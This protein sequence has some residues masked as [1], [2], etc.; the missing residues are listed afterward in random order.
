MCIRDSV[1]T[2]TKNKDELL[3]YLLDKQNKT[4]N[5]PMSQS[6]ADF[7]YQQLKDAN[8]HLKPDTEMIL[9][10]ENGQSL[11]YLKGTDTTLDMVIKLKKSIN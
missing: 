2:A 5:Q 4:F 8:P 11:L 10:E 3:V 6:E 9:Y 7:Y 1:Y